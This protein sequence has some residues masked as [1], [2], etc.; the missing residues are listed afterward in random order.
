[1]K[2]LGYTIVEIHKSK[3]NWK[4]DENN[5]QKFLK[6]FK[7]I[8]RKRKENLFPPNGGLGPILKWEKI[9]T[10][11]HRRLCNNFYMQVGKKKEKKKTCTSGHAAHCRFGN[12][13]EFGNFV[14]NP[15]IRGHKA[16][17]QPCASSSRVIFTQGRAF[18]RVVEKPKKQPF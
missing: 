12:R 4:L 11:T 17:Q 8:L 3:I 2:D 5:I 9:S 18:A 6:I 14:W 10:P 7:K 16:K 15:Q 13:I 1:M